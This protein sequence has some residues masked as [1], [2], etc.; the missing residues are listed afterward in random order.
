MITELSLAFLQEKQKINIKMFIVP[1]VVLLCCF[2]FWLILA[3]CGLPLVGG[4]IFFV[5]LVINP[6]AIIAYLIKLKI[7][8]LKRNAKLLD[9]G[10]WISEMVLTK[11]EESYTDYELDTTS[12]LLE[13]ISKENDENA[14][15]F[16]HRV[17]KKE[18]KN[19]VIGCIY[20]VIHLQCKDQYGEK[21]ILENIYPSCQYNLSAELKPFLVEY[22]KIYKANDEYAANYWTNRI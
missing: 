21:F 3:I 12:Y 15:A 18:Y 19:A 14:V 17:S 5:V 4:I 2:I 1:I 22:S 7:D 10:L 11:K 8:E 6:I 9:N 20:Y 13:F 16:T